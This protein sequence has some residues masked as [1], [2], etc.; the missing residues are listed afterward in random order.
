[1]TGVGSEQYS[2]GGAHRLTQGLGIVL[3]YSDSLSRI[4]YLTRLIGYL[5][6]S[7]ERHIKHSYLKIAT[8]A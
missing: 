1:M 2:S 7:D 8:R 3:S 5:I 6:E 4:L